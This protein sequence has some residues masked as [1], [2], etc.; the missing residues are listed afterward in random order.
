[1]THA[2]LAKEKYVSLATFKRSGDKV[3]TPVWAAPDGD[4]LF[5]FSEAK[6]GKVKRLRNSPRAEL[7][8]CTYNGRVTGEWVQAEAVI[9]EAEEDIQRAL[10]ALRG[11]YGWQ[12]RIADMGAKL[13][14][15]FDARAYIRVSLTPDA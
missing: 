5:V 12:M 11:K 1:M 8:A 10:A 6:A 9:I 14:G 4:D 15:R 13:T 7:A 3:A 2:N